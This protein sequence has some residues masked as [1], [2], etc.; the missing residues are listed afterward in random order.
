MGE[1]SDLQPRSRIAIPPPLF[2]MDTLYVLCRSVDHRYAHLLDAADVEAAFT[3]KRAYFAAEAEHNPLVQEIMTGGTVTFDGL[4]A[5]DRHAFLVG[6]ATFFRTHE[7]LRKTLATNHRIKV[8][9]QEYSREEVAAMFARCVPNARLERLP[10]CSLGRYRVSLGLAWGATL[11]TAH[12]TA[13]G[14]DV[15]LPVDPFVL[16]YMGIITTVAAL[17]YPSLRQNR[18]VRDVAPWN[19]AMYLDLNADLLRRNNRAVAVARKEYVPQERPL[20]T[21][22]FYYA[23]A[24]TIEAHGF[25]T[26][27][28]QRL[29]APAPA[30]NGNQLRTAS[31]H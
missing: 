13:R 7:I 22:R 26:E 25:D 29:S 23:L 18:D 9:Q 1:P 16:Y 20:K 6:P 12:F 21:P 17:I 14:Q 19:S 11:L 3:Q 15:D 24:R 8:G 4:E 30:G 5:V 31:S 2:S 10:W 27:L 28:A